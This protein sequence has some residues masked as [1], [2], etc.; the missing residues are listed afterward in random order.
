MRHSK[1]QVVNVDKLLAYFNSYI[2]LNKAE[3]ETLQSCAVEKAVKRREFLLRENAVCRHYTFVVSGLFKTYATD[4]NGTAHIIQFAPENDW[5]VD[6]SSFH[7]E[8]PSLLSIQALEPSIVLQIDKASLIHA[9]TNHSK[10][11]IYFRVIIENSFVELQNRLLRNLSI[12]AK[13]RYQEFLEIHPALSN[14]LPNTQIASYLGI[15]PEFLSKLRAA[16]SKA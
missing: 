4:N 12:S 13:E 9:F 5:A 7:S 1:R 8:R 14:R 10:F 2:P 11:N 6:I 3:K 16:R 15:T